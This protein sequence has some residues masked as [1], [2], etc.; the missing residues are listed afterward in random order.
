MLSRIA[1]VRPRGLWH[2]CRVKTRWLSVVGV[3]AV[4]ATGGAAD[5]Q[6]FK[7]FKGKPSLGLSK[8]PLPSGTMV[9]STGV[10]PAPTS[11]TSA[12]SATSP[13]VPTAS[14]PTAPK[15]VA[16]VPAPAPATR[17]PTTHLAVTPN[18][19]APKRHR[20]AAAGGTEGDEEVIVVDDDDA[21]PAPKP[22]AKK[23]KPKKHADDD[24]V[25][26]TDDE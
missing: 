10:A 21:A 9:K 22:K 12:T 6:V 24:D 14:S 19:K 7:P 1:V 3:A 5:A 18:P 25:T 11:A 2:A 16:A 4:L 13:A 23:P 17:A 26:V 8:A 15:A 20:P